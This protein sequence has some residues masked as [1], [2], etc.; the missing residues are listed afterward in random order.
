MP[1]VHSKTAR[2][3]FDGVE[4]GLSNLEPPR[5]PELHVTFLTEEQM[6]KLTPLPFPPP[7]PIQKISCK[8]ERLDPESIKALRELANREPEYDVTMTLTGKQLRR[9]MRFLF[10]QRRAGKGKR[11]HAR[12]ALAADRREARR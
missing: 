1:V 5:Q 10:G 2:F 11:K 9:L 7:S 3:I 4:Y 12:R 8:V 6:D